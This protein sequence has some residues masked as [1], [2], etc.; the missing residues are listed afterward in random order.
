MDIETL[1]SRIKHLIVECLQIEGLDPDEIGDDQA[2]FG[3]GLGLDSVDALELVLGLETEFGI[4][5]ESDEMR[6]E[7]FASVNALADFV[8]SRIGEKDAASS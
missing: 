3:E 2:I 1:R 5:V 4:K 8:Q 7:S 6:R